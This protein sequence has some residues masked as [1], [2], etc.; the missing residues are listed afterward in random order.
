MAQQSSVS[1]LILLFICT[2]V[3]SREVLLNEKI[4]QNNAT[5]LEESSRL[6][7]RSFKFI[8]DSLSVGSNCGSN[9][10]IRITSKGIKLGKVVTFVKCKDLRI[11]SHKPVEVYCINNVSGV[12]YYGLI[13]KNITGLWMKNLNMYHCQSK[14]HEHSAAAIQVFNSRDVKFESLQF[15]YSR[16]TAV[17]F[18]NTFGTVT[19]INSSFQD[20]RLLKR[21]EQIYSYPGGVHIV[22]SRNETRTTYTLRNCNFLRN[23]APHRFSSYSPSQFKIRKDWKGAGLGG[24][25]GII[26]TGQSNG[27]NLSI[28]NS[29]FTGNKALWGGGLHIHCQGSASNNT[30][31]IRKTNFKCNRA[32]Q[33]GGGINAGFVQSTPSHNKIL[34]TK[35]IF[36]H[37]HAVNGGGT[38]LFALHANVA[39]K[40]GDSMKFQNCTWL[41]NTAKVSAAVGIAPTRWDRLSQGFLPVSIFKNCQF[42]NNEL[43]TNSRPLSAKKGMHYS[44]TQY[45]G[46]FTITKASVVFQGATIFKQNKHTALHTISSHVI[47]NKQSR[48]LFQDNYGSRGAALAM[49][50][51]SSLIFGQNSSFNFTNNT[52][53]T[54]GGA[55]YYETFDQNDLTFG[56][57]CFLQYKG[58]NL[59]VDQRNVHFK[60]ERNRAQAGSSIYSTTFYPCFFEWF[61][62]LSQHKL[63]QFFECIATFSFDDDN[64]LTNSLASNGRKF[65]LEPNLQDKI[66]T[67]PGEKITV[68]LTFLDEFR[69]A[70]STAYTL[71]VKANTSIAIDPQYAVGTTANFYGQEYENFTFVM[72]NYQVRRMDA[73]INMYLLPCPPGFYYNNESMSCEC[74]ADNSSQA[75]TG[76]TKCNT[77]AFYAY[78]HN[79]YWGGYYDSLNKTFYTAPCPLSF[80][81]LTST[82]N[83]SNA[84]FV[85]ALPNSKDELNNVMCGNNRKGILCGECQVNKS[86]YYHS[87]NYECK[88]NQF[89]KLG[90]LFYILS[91][92]FPTVI[93]F[94][95]IIAFNAS[96]TSGNINGFI[97]FCQVL[98][99]T[100][101]NMRPLN[102]KILAITAFFGT[103]YEILNLDFFNID[104]LSFCLWEGT[105]VMDILAFKYVTV[106]FALILVIGS[107]EFTFLYK[108]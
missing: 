46:V 66:A 13:F 6:P 81:A 106:L 96:F 44:V 14:F 85:Y 17:V 23:K 4:G 62:H 72:S 83:F 32:T 75:F 107:N 89:C 18:I 2:C 36:N 43:L 86:V 5:C 58:S 71:R 42:I 105:T 101:L 54:V 57:K 12:H 24:G 50:G 37:N 52:A 8:A 16:D 60:F 69:Q 84:H 9:L 63:Q 30:V 41:Y 33:E 61:D 76:M 38:T 102:E 73:V 28:I 40:A 47:F 104:K 90:F 82:S 15:I 53:T 3:R 67:I 51:F 22:F 91:E 59:T 29:N 1:L 27:I 55:I 94:S 31:I 70:R 93:L 26:F 74:A 64:N 39:Q 65:K 48:V 87:S 88:Q 20:N 98:S 95:V 77:S 49:Y 99:T 35:C 10:T 11:L 25:L 97:F 78:I 92:I 34:V 56:R 100:T 19:I 80:C 79:G 45:S 68:P 21:S 103:F 7:C 108:A